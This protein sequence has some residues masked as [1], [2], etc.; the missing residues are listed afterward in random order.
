MLQ[1]DAG[2]EQRGI[3]VEAAHVDGKSGV[4]VRTERLA[5]LGGETMVMGGQCHVLSN[6][7]CLTEG[8]DVPALDAVLFL[9]PRKSQIDVVQAVGRVMRRAPGKHY[10]YVILPV[11]VPAGEDPASA[12]DRNKAYEHVWQVLQAL[13]SH[14]ERFDAWVNKLD[15]NRDSTSGPVSVIGIGPRGGTAEDDEGSGPSGTDGGSRGVVEEAG[16]YVLSGID[17][18]I[19]QWREAIYAKIVERCGERRYWERWAESVTDIARRHHERIRALIAA[20]GGADERFAEFVAALRNNLNDA[21]SDDDAAAM[22]SQHLITRPV[23][24]A[25]FGGSEFTAL[26]PVSQVMQRMADELEGRGLEAETEDLEGFYASVRRRVEG[27]DTN[28]GRQR[29]A[30]ELYDNS[31]ARRSRRM[32]SASASSTPRLRSSTSSST[33]LQTCCRSTSGPRWAMKAC[34]SWNRSPGRAHSSRGCW[35]RG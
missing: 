5:W 3:Q 33:R 17:E 16:Q 27:I 4:L 19:E 12:L 26:N 24:D 14:D 32:P 29:V 8:I 31:S 1:D 2:R 21:I 20:P 28:E 22:L 11:V 35:R 10:G 18:R 30:I 23:F 7:R 6:A 13:R 25:L 15:L 34:T 9:Q